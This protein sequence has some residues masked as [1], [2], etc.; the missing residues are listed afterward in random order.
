MKVYEVDIPTDKGLTN[1]DIQNYA[2]ILKIPNFRG[3]F[4]RDELPKIPKRFEC[5]IMNFNTHNQLGTHW[6]CFA[7]R[8]KT[9][10]Y[11]DSFGQITPVEIQ[12]YLK[13]R[14][15][16][17]NNIPVIERNTDIVQRPNTS[18]CGHLCLFVLTAVMREHLTYQ[19]VL[20]QLNSAFSEDERFF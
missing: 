20:Y 18:I 7:K 5:G 11:F 17:Q 8:G 16:F 13:T 10:I 4:M 12:R 2:D 15:E 3:V 1:F 14:F 9:C 6:V 19:K